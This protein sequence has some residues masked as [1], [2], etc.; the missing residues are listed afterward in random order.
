MRVRSIFATD[1]GRGAT[2]ALVAGISAI[3]LLL[4]VAAAAVFLRMPDPNV[5]NE[6]VERIFAENDA[7]TGQAE[8]RLLEILAQSGTAFAET[9]ATYRVLIFV[10]LVFSAALLVSAIIFLILFVALN[11]RMSEIERAGIEIRSLM[12]SRDANAVYLNN[13][14]FSLTGA[15][16][17]TLAALAEARLD[18]EILSGAEIEAIVTGKSVDTCDEAAGATRIKRLRDALGNQIVS[19][20]LIRTVARKGYMLAIEKDVIRIM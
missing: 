10:L 6:R 1:L 12:L 19:Q 5:F 8:V 9:L 7:L 11:R 13:M 4:L 15:A 3:L 16:M 17:E 2:R 20:L 18:D 14:E